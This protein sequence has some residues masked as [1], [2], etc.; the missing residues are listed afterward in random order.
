MGVRASGHWEKPVGPA[1][2][3]LCLHP[4]PPSLPRS[5]FPPGPVRF[6]CPVRVSA[7]SRQRWHAGRWRPGL[8]RPGISAEAAEGREAAAGRQKG[9]FTEKLAHYVSLETFKM[10]GL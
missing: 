9:Q 3:G 10:K 8:W 1:S 2:V 5:G 4:L 7:V 6:S